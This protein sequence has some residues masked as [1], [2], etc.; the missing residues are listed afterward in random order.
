[1]ATLTEAEATAYRASVCESPAC[2][3][4][5]C[6]DNLGQRVSTASLGLTDASLLRRYARRQGKPSGDREASL[7]LL[8]R[9]GRM[10]TDAYDPQTARAF[11]RSS[12]PLLGDRAPVTVIAAE[13]AEVAGAEVLSAARV[14]LE[15]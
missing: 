3:A 2:M 1:M 12:N 4:R 7:R 10:L 11:L 5:W 9:I 8:Y 14:L 13:P 15:G 6:L